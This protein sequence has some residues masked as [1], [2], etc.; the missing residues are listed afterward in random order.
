MPQ[1]AHC[2]F[3][4]ACSAR[5]QSANVA[6]PGE[7]LLLNTCQ[8]LTYAAKIILLKGRKQISI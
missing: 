4:Y 2:G 1:F 5:K 7:E 3:F 8:Y 6:P